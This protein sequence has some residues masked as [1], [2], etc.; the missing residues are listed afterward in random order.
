MSCPGSRSRIELDRPYLSAGPGRQGP[1]AGRLRLRQAR[2]RRRGDRGAS[3]RPTVEPRDAPDRS[4]SAPTPTGRPRSSSRCPKRSSAASRTPVTRRSPSRRPSATPPARPSRGP[5][6]RVVTSQPI[7]IEVI[8]EGGTLVQ[9][10]PNTI[11]LLTSHARRPARRGRGST[12]SGLDHE[13]RTER[14]WAQPRSSSPRTADAVSWTDPGR[15]RS[16]PDRPSPGRPCRA[17]S[18][19]RRLP[20]PHRQG[21]LSTAAS[22]CRVLALGGGVEPVFLDLIKD[23]QTVLSES[24]DVEQGPR[25]AG[26]STCRPSCP[27]RSSCAPTA[28]VRTGLPVR[29]SRVVHDPAGRELWRSRPASTAPNTGRASGPG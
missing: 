19:R 2:R 5:R 23:G 14:R 28:T 12:V 6:P 8:P 1:R 16:G 20:R 21:G 4:S 17:A 18:R 11:H 7:R 25:R 27:A 9:G 22:R 3:R 15:G 24:I 26:R 10:L 29:Q 13:L